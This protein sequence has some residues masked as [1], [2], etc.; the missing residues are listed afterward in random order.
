MR[1]SFYVF[2]LA[3]LALLSLVTGAP[4]SALAPVQAQGRFTTV[5]A[6]MVVRPASVPTST[7]GSVARS[8]TRHGVPWVTLVVREERATDTPEPGLGE[9][10]PLVGPAMT[11]PSLPTASATSSVSPEHHPVHRPVHQLEMLADAFTGSQLGEIV[12]DLRPSHS[13]DDGD[14]VNRPADELGMLAE[15]LSS[16]RI[17]EI[18]D[19]LR[20]SHSR[21]HSEFKPYGCGIGLFSNMEAGSGM[22][23]QCCIDHDICVGDCPTD[24]LPSCNDALLQCMNDV[25]E[26][27]EGGFVGWLRKQWCWVQRDIYDGSVRDPQARDHFMDVS[28]ERCHCVEDG[29]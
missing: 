6:S 16:S 22:F 8:G 24:D 9:E 4:L 19:D 2:V 1:A 7:A 5:T 23:G 3:T 28:R 20:P 12:D 17:G 26:H 13:R 18:V 11:T 15:A 25:C 21:N 14:S 29:L 27:L 10:F